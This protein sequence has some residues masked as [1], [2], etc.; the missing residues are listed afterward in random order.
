MRLIS[1][2]LIKPHQLHCGGKV[3]LSAA[4]ISLLTACGNSSP[5]EAQQANNVQPDQQV[6]Q[7]VEQVSAN[8]SD[9]L[10][11]V[12]ATVYKDPNCGC[13]TEWID[14]AQKAGMHAAVQH[15]QNLSVFKEKYRVPPQM[16]SCHTAVTE[17]GYVF[18][19][20]V[21][22]KFIAQFLDNP[23][24][25]AIGLTVPGMPVG[26]PGMEVDDQFMAY[27]VYQINKDGS[28]IEFASVDT[29]QQQL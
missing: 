27:K 13:C 7:Q 21:P 8:H 25:D 29:P 15:P 5:V 28:V 23:P 3:M 6:E 1:Q 12:S 2:H 22:A 9:L 20:H 24:A 17:D 18:E 4:V 16:Q 10:Q 11:G 26:S 19:G 14:Y